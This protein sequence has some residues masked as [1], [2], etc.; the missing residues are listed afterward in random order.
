MR[1][2]LLQGEGQ[3]TMRATKPSPGATRWVASM[4]A[5]TLVLTACQSDQNGEPF[6]LYTHCGIDDVNYSNQ[7]YERVGGP[8]DDGSGNPPDGWDNPEH[9]GTITRLDDSTI[10]FTDDDGHREEFTLRA[11]ATGPTKVCE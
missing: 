9:D 4:A 1:E 2:P 11:N 8:L 5:A 6:T 3:S 7:W 10:V